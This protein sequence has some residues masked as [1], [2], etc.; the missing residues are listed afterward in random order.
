[1]TTSQI[2]ILQDKV[3]WL[4][5]RLDKLEQAHQDEEKHLHFE[6]LSDNVQTQ[7][8][9]GIDNA[10]AQTFRISQTEIDKSDDPIYTTKWLKDHPVDSGRPIP[11]PQAVGEPQAA[12]LSEQINKGDYQLS[13]TLFVSTA[14]D[15]LSAIL[16]FHEN[17]TKHQRNTL[18]AARG[19][20]EAFL[21]SDRMKRGNNGDNK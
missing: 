5:D 10:K 2:E 17:L 14:I 16:S 12:C 19:S 8:K 3:N 15:K 7:V 18:Q 21:K 1:M 6:H 9:Q 20:L 4:A 11:E 13:T